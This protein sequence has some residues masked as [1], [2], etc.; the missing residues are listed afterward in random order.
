MTIDIA[1]IV[2]EIQKKN[3][4]MHQRIFSH[5]SMTNRPL[6]QSITLHHIITISAEHVATSV[7]VGKSSEWRSHWYNI[8]RRKKY[9]YI[10][11]KSNLLLVAFVMAFLNLNSFDLSPSGRSVSVPNNSIAKLMYYLD[12]MCSLIEYDE[13]N[14]NRLRDYKNYDDLSNIELRL[15]YV[16]C[17]TLDP[18]DFK[19]KIIFEDRD[20]DLCGSSLNRMYDL[21]EI[22]RRL[23]VVR[24]VV[25]AG[26]TRRVKKIMAYR[27][28]WLQLY[29]I[30]PI[31]E[32]AAIFQRE[33][34]Q[35]AVL[36][37]INTCTISWT[38]TDSLVSMYKN[39]ISH[40]RPLFIIPMNKFFSK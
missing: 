27:P 30:Q 4:F 17:V 5:V 33:R 10:I 14:L 22:Q 35:Q 9:K 1:L 36:E 11:S 16:T 37:L 3:T 38:L 7:S 26:Q 15:L 32:L 18:D 2:L 29:Y 24:S 20:G 28:R 8:N 6:N 13:S 39:I 40:N 34:Q 19:G 12:C 31:A 25:L 21:G 23:V